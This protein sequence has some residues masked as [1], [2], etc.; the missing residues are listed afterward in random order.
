VAARIFSRSGI[1][2]LAIAARSPFR[3]SIT[4][5]NGT[6]LASPG[7]A[8]ARAGTCSSAYSTNEYNGCSTHSVPSWSK[9]AMRSSGG[10]NFELPGVVVA[11][12]KATMACLDAPSFHDGSGSVWA[13]T[14]A[15]SASVAPSVRTRT[16]L[17]MMR[18]GF[19]R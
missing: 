1:V 16:R 7:F 17:S 11:C 18:S 8:F 2:S 12:T 19:M 14:C 6:I 9:V 13:C 4:V 15:P 10:T 5:E 3:I